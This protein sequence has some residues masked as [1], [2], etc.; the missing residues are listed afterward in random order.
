MNTNA[1]VEVVRDAAGFEA[2]R[3]E[4]NDLLASSRSDCLFLTWEWLNC[5]WRHL[6]QDRRL[7]IV[8]VR[9]GKRLIAIAPLA[10]RLR[11]PRR[12]VPYRA[13][14]FLGS[15]TAGSD[16]LDVIVRAGCE[17]TAVEAI[18]PA[19]HEAGLAL[20]LKQV[21]REALATRLAARLERS[22]WRADESVTNVCP[23][24][25]LA[26]HT[27]ETYL[28]SL[29]SEH[30]YNFKRK[31]KK[32]SAQ[33]EVAF[34]PAESEVECR[35]AF[36]ALL[37]LH[38]R[39]WQLRREPSDAF[40][41]LQH[42]AF[43]HEFT[44]LALCRGWL[45]LLTLRLNGRAAGSLYG[46]QYGPHFSFYQ[47]GFDPDFGRYSVGLLTMGLAIRHAIEDGAAEYDLLHGAE[48]YKFHW[49][50]DRRDL[51]RVD[52]FPPGPRGSLLRSY[53]HGRHRLL[54]MARRL[55]RKE[56]PVK[57]AALRSDRNGATAY[58]TGPAKDG[59]CM[60]IALDEQQ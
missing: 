48:E 8:T 46:F 25:P 34:V 15:G 57:P 42:V 38:E 16:Y 58:A 59:N 14:E 60:G 41:T 9:E 18:A 19:L 3:G 29:G 4:W 49:A 22:Q 12:L 44:Q 50:R 36:D 47:S 24:I 5:W 55:L 21:R 6:G 51:L 52:L 56:L 33:F 39:R 28:A 13:L 23:Y 11:E 53:A 32:L 2:L 54:G 43:H 10:L 1:Q 35:Q 26:G 20:E 37:E 30:R 7:H 17:E 40:H 27:W 31:L 45:R